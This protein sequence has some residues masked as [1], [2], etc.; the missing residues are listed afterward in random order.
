MRCVESCEFLRRVELTEARKEGK[1]EG[2]A[3][4]EER[5]KAEGKRDVL[6]MLLE[7][8]GRELTPEQRELIESCDDLARLDQ[9]IESALA[10]DFDH[11]F[12]SSS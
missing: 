2:E 12:A 9:W 1:A 4:G 3:I 11:I 6:F 10:G 7:R 5:V 8:A